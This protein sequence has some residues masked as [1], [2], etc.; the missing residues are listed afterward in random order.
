MKN[1]LSA[2]TIIST[3]TLLLILPLSYPNTGIQSSVAQAV[4]R[5]QTYT[6][7][8][9]FSIQYP[10]NWFVNAT[11]R[12]YVII[13]NYKPQVGGGEA[14]ANYMKTDITFMPGSLE[15]AVSQSIA[16]TRKNF[17]KILKRETITVAGREAV[18]I[19]ITGSGFD[20]PDTIV[21]YVRYTNKETATMATFYTK[22]NSSAVDIIKRI[23]GSF[24]LIK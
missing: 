4:R 7:P 16:S 3:V 11:N 14:P 5:F 17:D 15:T 13:T 19:W 12:R 6:S 2:L 10:S 20:F 1:K 9:L 22:S 23:H 18:R 8:K 24:R 21:T